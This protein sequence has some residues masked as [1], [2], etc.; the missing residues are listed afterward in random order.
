MPADSFATWIL[1]RLPRKE[2]NSSSAWSRV[3]KGSSRWTRFRRPR[4]SRCGFCRLIRKQRSMM[5]YIVDRTTMYYVSHW[6]SWFLNVITLPLAY[7]I[8]HISLHDRWLPLSRVTLRSLL[9][10]LRVLTPILRSVFVVRNNR[11]FVRLIRRL[12]I[13]ADTR[14]WSSKSRLISISRW[15]ITTVTTCLRR[16]YEGWSG[17]KL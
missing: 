13:R 5:K 17:V 11:P 1:S 14:S 15:Y 8:S 9:H 2:R 4:L 3:E 6:W 10:T 7:V 12:C 16:N